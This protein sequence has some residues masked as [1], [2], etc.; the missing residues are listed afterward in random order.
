MCTHFN[1]NVTFELMMSQ[2]A[3]KC[4][5]F[6]VPSRS[7]LSAHGVGEYREVTG[8]DRVPQWFLSLKTPLLSFCFQSKFWFEQEWGH[9]GYQ[10]SPL[11]CDSLLDTWHLE[12]TL[13]LAALPCM[14][15]P[16]ESCAHEAFMN[17]TCTRARKKWLGTNLLCILLCSPA[18]C[19][20]KHKFKDKII[21]NFKDGGS[22]KL[23]QA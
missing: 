15:G 21:Q 16:P 17:T 23:N 5:C 2:E 19:P 11:P 10:H 13:S 14:R 4:S 12:L 6:P 18:P 7:S 8:Y 1:H 3:L 22:G 20:T 9:L